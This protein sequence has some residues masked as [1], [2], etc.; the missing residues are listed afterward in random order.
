MS[1]EWSEERF[2][3][4][5]VKLAQARG[6]SVT[7]VM[8]QA[9]LTGD[10]LAHPPRSG[11]RI[12]SLTRIARVLQVTVSHLIGDNEAPLPTATLAKNRTMI[13]LVA[14]I[15]LYLAAEEYGSNG[16]SAGFSAS[17]APD[18]GVAHRRFDGDRRSERAAADS[19]RELSPIPQA[20]Q[21]AES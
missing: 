6:M 9:G 8:R 17:S 19:Y 12:D 14:N 11:R 13:S 21:A 18:A 3:E 4:R 1:A 10:F 16:D 7:A 2:A 5:V 15:A 20:D